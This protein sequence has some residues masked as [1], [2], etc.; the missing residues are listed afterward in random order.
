MG[1][2]RLTAASLLAAL[3]VAGAVPAV[4]R[5]RLARPIRRPGDRARRG[6]VRRGGHGRRARPAGPPGRAAHA[7]RR[8]S[9]GRRRGTPRARSRRPRRTRVHDVRRGRGAGDRGPRPRLAGAGAGPAAGVPR[10]PVTGPGRDRLVSRLRRDVHGRASLLRRHR[11]RTGWTSWTTRSG[12]PRRGRLSPT[13]WRSAASPSHSSRW[14][15][16][17]WPSCVVGAPAASSFASR[18]WSSVSP[19]RCPCWCCRSSPRPGAALDVR[20]RVAA[21][22]GGGGGGDVPA[23][24][25]RRAACGQPHPDLRGAFGGAG[26]LY[27]LVVVGVGVLLQE[28]G[29]P[30]LPLAAAAVVAV[31]FAPLRDTLQGAVNR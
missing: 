5:H 9:L 6:G 19:S 8:R 22:P 31:A 24:P 16:W 1:A 7:A 18:S 25:V 14:P 30:W 15:S 13:C 26:R 12:S 3:A 29:A 10:R 20:A 23:P 28:R 21:G 11:S 4:V 27:A 17:S 2:F